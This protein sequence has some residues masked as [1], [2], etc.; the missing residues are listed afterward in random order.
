MTDFAAQQLS[1]TIRTKSVMSF[2]LFDLCFI[3]DKNTL[4]LLEKAC[5]RN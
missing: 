1:E 5:P 2:Q 3:E 4:I